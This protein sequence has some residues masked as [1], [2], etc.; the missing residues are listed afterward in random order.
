MERIRAAKLSRRQFVQGAAGV[1]LTTAGLALLAGCGSRG[2]TGGPLPADARLETTTL[3]IAWPGNVCA[4]PVRVAEELLRAEGFNDVQYVAPPP[5]VSAERLL[6]DGGADLT[7]QYAPT[8]IT[9]VDAGKATVILAGIHAGCLALFGND[10]VRAMRDLKGKTIAVSYQVTPPRLFLSAMLAYV[11]LDPQRDVIWDESD[12]PVALQRFVDGKAD[13]YITSPPEQQE[14][15]ARGIGHVLVDTAVDRP[16]SQHFCCVLAGNG[17]FVQRHPVATKRALRA[18]LKA[19]EVCAA[20]PEQAAR[21]A[22]EKGNAGSYE[23]SLQGVQEIPYTRWREFDAED[24]V[25]FYALQLRD[26]GLIQSSPNAI[27]ERGTDWRFLN[28]LKRELKG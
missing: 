9:Q 5:G 22:V 4:V 24:A 3:R 8:F 25:R 11:G 20:E 10:Q 12:N 14:L 28:D 17:D 23:Y 1:G 15:R 16:W 26:G 6:A 27:V 2:T 13:A 19:V 21:T 7:Q 18:I